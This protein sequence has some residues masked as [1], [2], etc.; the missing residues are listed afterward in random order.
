MMLFKITTVAAVEQ[1]C[2][3]GHQATARNNKATSWTVPRSVSTCCEP[4]NRT[5]NI[6]P[7]LGAA[8]A[9]SVTEASCDWLNGFTRLQH[10]ASYAVTQKM[11]YF[12][13]IH[14]FDKN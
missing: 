11:S 7:S 3:Y 12:V 6:E 13:M 5:G 8:A 1:Q 10:K 4:R 14:I 2:H 9:P